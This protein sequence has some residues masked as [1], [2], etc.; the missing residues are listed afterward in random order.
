MIMFT[1]TIAYRGIVFTVY[2]C[3]KM[4]N[5]QEFTLKVSYQYTK[6]I[7]LEDLVLSCVI[8]FV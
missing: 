1:N 2:M 8:Q 3:R 7:L 5:I 6:H 4:N